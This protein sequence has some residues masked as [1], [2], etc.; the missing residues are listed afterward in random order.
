MSL[1][2][3]TDLEV[4]MVALINAERAKFDLAPVRVELHLNSAA[5]GHSDWMAQARVLQ[6]EGAGNSNPTERM[7]ATDMDFAGAWTTRE[8]VGYVGL[9]GAYDAGEV[10]ALHTALMNSPHHR[11]NIL[12]E[13]V[14]YIGIGL[15]EGV[16]TQGGRDYPV[17]FVTQNFAS[18]TGDVLVQDEINGEDVAVPFSDGEPSGEPIAIQDLLS[19][20]GTPDTPTNPDKPTDN[21]PSDDP[22]ADDPQNEDDASGGGC[23][24]ATA[25]YG[26]RMHPDV[27]DLRTFR[28]D[29][30]VKSA[31]G[32]AFVRTYWKVGPVMA[33][34]VK[35]NGGS[36]HLTRVALRPVVSLARHLI[37]K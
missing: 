28:D 35:A 3:A 36:G 25:A 22:D 2:V 13:E 21:D 11:E 31:P 24:V 29:I 1:E 7:Q 26:H 23:F 18:T 14:Q 32:R 4:Q 5:Q 33:K 8:N 12:A 15:S 10:K 9:S 17:A 19:D 16:I 6:H 37:Q 30:L 27:V 20:S 34:V